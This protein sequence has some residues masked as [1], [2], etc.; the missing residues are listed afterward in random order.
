MTPLSQIISDL[1]DHAA[2]AWKNGQDGK[3]QQLK[4]M[5]SEL[6][7]YQRQEDIGA[8][9]LEIYKRHPHSSDMDIGTSGRSRQEPL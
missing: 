8:K 2:Q 7:D 1:M 3:A 4:Q 9:L 5:A 6:K